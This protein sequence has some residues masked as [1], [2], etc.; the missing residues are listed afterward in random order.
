MLI[1]ERRFDF[2]PQS[3]WKNL[4]KKDRSKLQSFKSYYGHYIRTENEIEELT[5]EIGK[6]EEKVKRYLSKMNK[7]NYEID[8]LRDDYHFSWSVSK[9]KNKNYYNL[10]IS[11]RGHLPKSGTLGSPKLIENHLRAYYKR[12]KNKLKDLDRLGWDRFIRSE[13]NDRSGRN[14]VRNRILDL[15][16]KDS[17]LK[18]I[19]INRKTLFPLKNDSNG[20]LP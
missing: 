9:L 19:V 12:N 11:R 15:I 16:T 14:K 10:T 6:K 1:D 20:K 17:T 2:L 7:L 3:K 8:H 4:S 5:K 18:S 13:V